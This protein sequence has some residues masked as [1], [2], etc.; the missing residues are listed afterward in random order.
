M[1]ILCFGFMNSDVKMLNFGQK[2]CT[3]YKNRTPKLSAYLQV[4][5][6]F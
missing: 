3:F 5:I 4:L 6:R 1:N 2:K